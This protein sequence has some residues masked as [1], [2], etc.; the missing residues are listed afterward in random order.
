[1]TLV[2][3]ELLL[4]SSSLENLWNNLNVTLMKVNKFFP[5]FLMCV[6]VCDCQMDWLH[7]IA[8]L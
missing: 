7:F 1:M 2:E 6:Y 5:L 3:M 8:L 4:L